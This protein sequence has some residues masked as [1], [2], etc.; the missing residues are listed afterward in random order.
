ML[1]GNVSLPVVNAM[2]ATALELELDDP[3]AL[4]DEQRH[5]FEERDWEDWCDP[6]RIAEIEHLRVAEEAYPLKRQRILPTKLGN[7][8]RA[9]EDQLQNTEDD[10]Q[11]F[12]LR[13]YAAAPPLVQAEHN[14]FRSRLDMYCTLVFVSSAL[15]VLTPLILLKS[16]IGIDAIV[17]IGVCFGA[18]SA[19]SYLAA[20]A[21]ARG[22]CSA[23][24]EM[25]RDFSDP[26]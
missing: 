10:V 23:L 12:A 4:T 18:L 1:K 25:D 5:E 15:L 26:S 14:K 7:L 19:A 11:G 8:I 22:Y 6:W 9:T 13:R 17:I 3:P 21:S 20:I 24:K 2:K 16:D